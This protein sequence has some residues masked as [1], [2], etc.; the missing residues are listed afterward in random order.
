MTLLSIDPSIR[1]AGVALFVAGRLVWARRVR[2]P[3]KPSEDVASRCLT[4]ARAIADHVRDPP[5]EL[6]TEWPKV[7]RGQKSKGDPADLF[8]LAGVG[9]GVAALLRPARVFSYTAGEWSRGIDKET[10]GDCRESPRARRIRSRLE[11][12]EV[13]VWQT[14]RP[15]DHDAIDSIGLGLAHLGRLEPRRVF[16]GAV[17]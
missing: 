10:K 3:S 7:Y 8:G 6:V 2:S 1:S 17:E 12:A 5:D 14:L 13:T 4:M 16:A 9:I 11:G 15:S